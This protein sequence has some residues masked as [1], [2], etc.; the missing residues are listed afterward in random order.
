MTHTET[1]EYQKKQPEQMAKD[2]AQ[3]Q[4][5]YLVWIRSWVQC[6]VQ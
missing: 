6:P 2:L 1:S 4:S 5:I 3:W